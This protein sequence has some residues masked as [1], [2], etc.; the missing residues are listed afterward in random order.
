[1]A[2]TVLI[3]EADTDVR[4]GFGMVFRRAGYRVLTASADV[5]AFALAVD[6]VPDLVT[7]NLIDDQGPDLCRALH[8][9]PRTADV[10]VLLMTTALY[11]DAAAAARAGA[12]DFMTKP[13]H[14]RDLLAHA[15]ALLGGAAP[16]EPPPDEPAAASP[17]RSYPACGCHLRGYHAA[18][19]H[20]SHH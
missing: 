16:D 18:R 20:H 14:N 1:M 11:P 8:A 5:T 10:P 17:G 3:V 2:A 6:E 15:H 4:I 9:H 13:L 7:I 19:H 12:D